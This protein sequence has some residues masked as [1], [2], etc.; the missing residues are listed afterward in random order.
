MNAVSVESG[1]IL[2][3]GGTNARIGTSSEGDVRGFSTIST[4]QQPK[5]FFSW[6]ARQVLDAAAGGN[7]WLVAGFPGPVSPD[8]R[9]VGPMAN[10]PGLTDA[11]YD[12]I[13]ELSAVDSAVGQLLDDNFSLIAVNDGELAAQA[14]ANRIGG[15][16]H[17]RTA[18]LILGT[19]VG[20]GIVDLDRVYKNVCRADRSNP[21]EIGHA[22]LS[23]DPFD[24][25]ENTVSGPALA[26]A[27]GK[28]ARELAADHPAWKRVGEVAGQL[29]TTLGVMNSVEL[30]V[31]C[32]GVGAGASDNYL[33]HLL[34]MIDNYRQYGN[35]TQK[36]FLPE[37]IPVPSADSQIFE[38][39]GGEGVV[40][41]FSTRNQG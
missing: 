18:A 11:R 19:G 12:L 33:P 25:F 5:E 37:I 39:F 9:L 4:P 10:V 2:G 16:K 29:A 40:R 41:D 24:T 13:Q 38:L 32:G 17:S 36:L 31:P 34:K 8:G 3:F 6:M 35:G 23:S 14:A 27:Y 7:H 22:L 1:V 15:Y 20:A 21:V 28:D 26:R 30:V